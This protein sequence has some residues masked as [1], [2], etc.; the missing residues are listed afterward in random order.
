[1]K[2]LVPTIPTW[3]SQRS[4]TTWL[5]SLSITIT[6][7]SVQ[8]RGELGGA[9][10]VPVVV[11]EDGDDGDLEVAHDVGD[12]LGLLGL[13]V[14]GQVAGQEHDVGALGQARERGRGPL[15]IVGALAVVDVA[16]G[17]DPD[18]ALVMA[19]GRPS[20]GGDRRAHAFPLPATADRVAIL[21]WPRMTSSP[22]RISRT[23]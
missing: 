23:R 16:G 9:V 17:G 14:G 15:A 19:V 11:A 3:V 10:D 8:D 13:A 21:I 6:P 5:W 18:P 12:D 4:S 20:F 1:M 2:P 7:A 22:S